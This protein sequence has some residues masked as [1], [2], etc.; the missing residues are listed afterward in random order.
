MQGDLLAD[1]PRARNTDPPTSHRAAARIKQSGALGRQQRLV[2]EWVRQ[3]P[4][5]TSAEIA[6]RMAESRDD[7]GRLWTAY[8]PMLGRRLPE[9]A[10]V[11]LRK[12]EPRECQVTGAESLTWWAR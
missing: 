5:H 8:R 11:H 2:L 1:L 10:P 4:G 12:G 9:L 3:Y 6:R 7:D